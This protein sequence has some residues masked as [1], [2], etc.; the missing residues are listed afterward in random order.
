M[1][2]C[3]RPSKS[4]MTGT[5]LATGSSATTDAAIFPSISSASGSSSTPQSSAAPSTA[6]APCSDPNPEKSA[7]S[8]DGNTFVFADPGGPDA[9][10]QDEHLCI[11]RSG[12]SAQIL[13]TGREEPPTASPETRLEGFRD[14]IFSADSTTLYF[15]SNAWATESAAHS[16]ELATGRERFIHSGRVGAVLGGGPWKGMLYVATT[17]LDEAYPIGSPKYAGRIA[18]FYVVSPAGKTLKRLPE[19][20]AARARMLGTNVVWHDEE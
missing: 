1:S 17:G 2:A 11:Q 7:T 16:V 10:P 18:F 12:A 15:V 9:A 20:D 6:V 13:L 14:F 4:E 8:P 3:S 19:D 5:P